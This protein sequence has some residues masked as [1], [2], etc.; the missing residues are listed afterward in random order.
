MNLKSTLWTLAFAVA[1]VS[2]SDELEEGGGTGTGNEENGEGVYVTVNVSSNV[3]PTTKAPGDDGWTPEGGDGDLEDSDVESAVHDVNIFLVPVTPGADYSGITANDISYVNLDTESTTIYS[4][5][6]TDVQAA[7]GSI[8]HHDLEATVRVGVPDLNQWYHVL[9]VVNAGDD[10]GFSTLGSLRD[11]LQKTAWKGD[12][13][14]AE[15]GTGAHNF[16]MSTHQMWQQEADGSDLYVTSDNTDP[17]N[18]AETTVYVERLAARIDLNLATGVTTGTAPV[19]ENGTALKTNDKVSITGYQVI[20]QMIGGTYMLK[21]VT[22]WTKLTTV[23]GAIP[24][25]G[26]VYIGDEIWQE[27]NYNYVIDPWTLNKKQTDGFPESIKNGSAYYSSTSAA[28]K[29]QPNS[30]DDY[31]LDGGLYT[32]HFWEGLN[33]VTDFMDFTDIPADIKTTDGQFT[34][35]LYVQEN[36]AD[37]SQQKKGFTTGV[38]FEGTYK[39]EHLSQYS[40]TD[41]KVSNEITYTEGSP[42]LVVDYKHTTLENRKP[43]ADLRTIA[44]LGFNST[45]QADVIKYIFNEGDKSSL[46][47][48]T[49]ENFKSAVN[50]M[51]GGPLVDAFQG[52]LQSK[53]TETFN[54]VKADLTWDAFVAASKTSDDIA[55]V[56]TDEELKSGIAGNPDGED[57]KTAIKVREELMENYNIAYYDGGKCYYKYWIKHEPLND[58]KKMGVMEFAIVRNNVYQLAVTGV[59][60]LGDPLPFTPGEDDPDDPVKEQEEV[61]ILV[62]LYVRDWVKRSNSGIIL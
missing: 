12:N 46:S 3:G 2:C 57:G 24:T 22:D 10:L 20:N 42:F 39:P 54:D 41:G 4:G 13:K 36:T 6:S 16:V 17:N 35:L 43:S 28:S 29:V 23:D 48:A 56:P 19:D 11:Y 59:T 52:Y 21:R 44:V 31:T 51:S 34:P 53:L 45:A 58:D 60:G 61:Q 30:S 7:T 49:E 14:Y 55:Y 47:N 25:D 50:G 8:P 33:S 5:Y 26:V 40:E 32:N 37:A 18:P 38:I 15:D 1:A 62:R 27:G 9:T